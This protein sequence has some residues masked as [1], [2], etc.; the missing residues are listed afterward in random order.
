M[1]NTTNYS[2]LQDCIDAYMV[3]T[4]KHCID[5]ME[6]NS[7]LARKGLMSDDE[8]HPGEPLRQLLSRLRDSNLLPRNIKHRFGSW[9][10]RN[11]HA[12]QTR[13]LIF[14]F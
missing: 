1:T 6:A 4:G 13:Q 2:A 11:S 7:E 12:T 5:E 14:L 8:E 3:R 9:S 10:I